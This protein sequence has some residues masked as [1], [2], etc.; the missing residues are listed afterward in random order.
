MI[1]FGSVKIG[2][3]FDRHLFSLFAVFFTGRFRDLF[4]LEG[5]TKN[6]RS[7]LRAETRR[8]MAVKKSVAELFV[9]PFGRIEDDADRFGVVLDV[10]VGGILVGGVVGVAGN[11]SRITHHGFYNALLRIE[12]ALRAPKSSHGGLERV[13]DVFGR[14]QEGTNLAGFGLLGFDHIVVVTTCFHDT[15][16]QFGAV[17][18]VIL[19]VAALEQCALC[20]FRMSNTVALAIFVVEKERFTSRNQNRCCQQSRV[21]QCEGRVLHGIVAIVAKKLLPNEG[22][23]DLSL[24]YQ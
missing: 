6:G 13:V 19:V 4:L 12:I 16:L 9:R 1:L 21:G 23:R 20:A 7:I 2:R 17:V 15:S 22:K 11:A 3:H 14:G 10:A 24:S 8:I 5:E 18:V